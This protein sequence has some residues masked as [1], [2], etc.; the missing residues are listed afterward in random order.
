MTVLCGGEVRGEDGGEAMLIGL[1][2]CRGVGV[3]LTHHHGAEQRD[4]RIFHQMTVFG[5]AT[6]VAGLGGGS[7]GEEGG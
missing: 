5:G 1:A 7:L 3:G 2:S 4:L 6:V